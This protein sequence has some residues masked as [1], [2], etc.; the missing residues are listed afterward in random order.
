MARFFGVVGCE[1]GNLLAS[2]MPGGAL[3]GCSFGGPEEASIFDEAATARAFEG[4]FSAFRGYPARAPEPCRSCEYLPL[5]KGGCRVVS[6]AHGD[7]WQPDPGCPRVQAYRA[8]AP[9]RP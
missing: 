9:L 3:T 5:C 4:G 7:W 6:A 1:G 8:G 2:V